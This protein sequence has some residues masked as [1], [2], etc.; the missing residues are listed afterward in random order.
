MFALP[1]WT[2]PPLVNSLAAR[3]W[4]KAVFFPNLCPTS[5]GRQL[6]LLAGVLVNQ[7]LIDQLIHSWVGGKKW[8][9]S[10]L[11]KVLLH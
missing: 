1:F 2:V 7:R 4:Q 5:V 3:T 10:A 6:L 8:C 11:K 9:N